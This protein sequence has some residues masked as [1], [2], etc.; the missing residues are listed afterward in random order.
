MPDPGKAYVRSRHAGSA[1]RDSET[2]IRTEDERPRNLDVHSPRGMDKSRTPDVDISHDPH[3]SR[4]SG[5]PPR[6]GRGRPRNSV[7]GSV[8]V[9]S[10]PPNLG[11]HPDRGD[12]P[13]TKLQCPLS[14]QGYT[15]SR[16]PVSAS[17][18]PT[19]DIWILGGK[20]STVGPDIRI[21]GD[22]SCMVRPGVR[23]LDCASSMPAPEPRFLGRSSSVPA[24]KVRFPDSTPSGPP[25]NVLG[26]PKCRTGRQRSS[27]DSRNE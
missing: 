6:R 11:L 8:R 13:H 22:N 5:I 15:T 23:I 10:R 1:S 21:P 7:A 2:P 26:A 14:T 18:M 3:A 16:I 19:S 27:F 24:L 4:E 17:S 9:R 12:T 20:S 25:P